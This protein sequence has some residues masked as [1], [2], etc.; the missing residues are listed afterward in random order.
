MFRVSDRSGTAV[1][2]QTVT[3]NLSAESGGAALESVTGTAD[4]DGNVVAIVNSE[5]YQ[6]LSGSKLV[7]LG[8]RMLGLEHFLLN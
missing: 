8:L 4:A 2:G 1:S 3:F 6:P 5:L 7:S